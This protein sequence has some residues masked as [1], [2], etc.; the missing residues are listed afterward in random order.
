VITLPVV[1]FA[2]PHV[3]GFWIVNWVRDTPRGSVA[4]A[5]RTLAG[6][7]ADGTLHTE[8]ESTHSLAGYAAAIDAATRPTTAAKVFFTFDRGN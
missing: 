3:R 1:V 6:L 8:V 7:V 2:E 4:A 5:Y